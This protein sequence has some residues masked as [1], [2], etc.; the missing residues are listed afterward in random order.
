[1]NSANHIVALLALSTF[2]LAQMPPGY[3]PPAPPPP[4]GPIRPKPEGEGGLPNPCDQN[5][6]RCRAILDFFKW[7]LLEANVVCLDC[8]PGEK[9]L[10]F[11]DWV[12]TDP[13]QQCR[14]LNGRIGVIY[15]EVEFWGERPFRY[16]GDK[17]KV[18]QIR[19][20]DPT[21]LRCP[22]C[23]DGTECISQEMG[24]ED[25]PITDPSIEERKTGK[26]KCQCNEIT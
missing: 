26:T 14:C 15:E 13:P 2:A 23:D 8:Q 5:I 20:D 3:V 6:C 1:M 10:L 19:P 7:D 18:P 25:C 17:Y 22:A 4:T 21:C 11:K 24:K 12:P 16:F 9:I